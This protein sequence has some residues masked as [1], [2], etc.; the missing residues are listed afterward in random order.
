MTDARNILSL[1]TTRT[2][3]IAGV[4]LVVV[5]GTFFYLGRAENTGSNQRRAAAAPVRVATVVRHDMPVVE[6]TL[7]KV[8]ANTTVQVTARVQGIVDSANFKE[9]QFVKKGDLLF[10]IDPRGFEAALAQ[11]R[12]L[13]ARDEAQ[14][15]N[16]SR[17]VQRYSSLRDKGNVSAQQ[18]DATMANA[19]A[20]AA[21]VA[22]DKAAVQLAELNLGYTRIHAP[23]DGKTGPVLIQPGNMVNAGGT[24]PLVTIAQMQPIKLSLN[25]PQTDLPRIQMRQRTNALRATIDV[26]DAQGKSLAADVDFIDNAVNN[27]S[28]T[29]E[30]RATFKNEDFSLVPGQLVNVTIELDNIVNALIVPRDAV[31]D[32][33]DGS[34][35]YKVV[36]GKAQP[37]NVKVLFDD[38]QNVAVDGD[39][40]PGDMIITEGQL[41][42]VPNGAVNVISA[43]KVGG[44]TVDVS[45]YKPQ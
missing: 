42:V 38:S 39:L 25:M 5:L 36:D 37:H 12:A 44:A 26:M 23:V 35:V 14:L 40:N 19:E 30:L 32:G 41:R 31:N 7:G 27:Q 8:I 2:R 1:L 33:P 17:D 4:A 24:T 22:A 20:L 6:H 3:I 29:I 13:L 18:F 9:G 15:K 10:Q 43:R 11:A 16:T 28:G 21:T 34:Y 45:A